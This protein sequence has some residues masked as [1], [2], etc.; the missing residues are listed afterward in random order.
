MKQKKRCISF[1][2]LIWAFVLVFFTM[3][4]NA[5]L[6]VK[7]GGF[8][9]S[10]VGQASGSIEGWLLLTNPGLARFEIVS[11]TVFKGERALKIEIDSLGSNA[12]DIQ[13]VA[14]SI[15]V[16]YNETYRYSIWA[17]SRTAGAKV[18]FTVGRYNYSEYGRIHETSLTTTWQKYT[19]E[20]TVT[21][22]EP[23]ARGP[24]HFSISGNAGNAV[25]IDNLRIVSI[26]ATKRPVI[27]EAESGALGSSLST[28]GEGEITYITPIVSQGGDYPSD[29]PTVATYQVTFPDSGSYN[30][31]VRL[32]VGSN[33]WNDD[34]FFYGN[35]FG[36]K[37]LNADDWIRVNGLASAGYTD[38]NEIVSEIGY[39]GDQVWK[40]VKLSGIE[41]SG[42]GWELGPV[43]VVPED[44]LT[45]TIQLGSREDGLYIDK[46]AFGR[47][48][49]FYRVMDLDN[50]GEGFIEIP[51]PPWP[52]PPLAW[53]QPKFVGN[54]Y[55]AP[56]LK[57]LE[58][59]WNQITPENAGKWGSV[60]GTRDVMN[61]TEL[62]SAYALAKRNGFPFVFHVLVWG[63]QQPS[64][65]SDLPDS[66]KVQEIREWFEAVRDRYQD[67]DYL[68]VVNEALS[69]PPDGKNGRANYM[70]ALGGTG[71]TGYDWV[72]N[73]FRMAREV[74]G[75]DTK[76]MLN[77]YSVINDG[78]RNA[79]YMRII[80]YLQAENLI[81]AV[82]EQG[83]YFTTNSTGNAT[84]KR[85]LDSLA[86]TGVP[87]QITELDIRA[88]NGDT[89]AQ[90]NEY[91]RVFRLFFEHPGVEGI[92]LWG[93]RPGMW[94][95]DAYLITSGDVERP[96][97]RWLRNYLDTLVLPQVSVNMPEVNIA[98]EYELYNSYPNPFNPTTRIMYKLPV[99]S[100]V[101]LK[102]YNVL[103][104]EIAT[105]VDGVSDAGNY[106]ATF[107]GRG[108]ASGM[109]VYR[110]QARPV[111]GTK[112][113]FVASK[114][115]VLLK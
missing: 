10:P 74:F 80:R 36:L 5:Q 61:W 113:S 51:S 103:G 43:F 4:L 66:E 115:F 27:V 57:R 44:S 64:W 9:N 84:L 13:V 23:Y 53:K 50:N 40:W 70:N 11:D 73:A 72:I 89:T 18:S 101:T 48:D 65:I 52:G 16:V 83:H 94:V 78:G 15:P 85:Y 71:V 100:Y 108:L 20:F 75:E 91:K 107:D 39:A 60:E 58:N 34:S 1:R 37:Q 92:T 67:I 19:F 38:S 28:A 47:A 33:P 14:D 81:D 86:S 55:S 12:W 96:A 7:N 25:F 54:I 82:G 97:L 102:V 17:R 46:I 105:L 106:E 69:N 3:S 24:I 21:A 2:A 41:N 6:L 98:G 109:Y 114:K 68:Q 59:Y 22:N 77:D 32:K 45:Q 42:A 26:N 49:L 110:M 31:Y 30:L 76:L 112:E 111:N 87:V 93:W 99:K 35:G 62:D 63:P 88:A 56:Q 8:E 29:T 104:Q 95:E 90:L 79:T